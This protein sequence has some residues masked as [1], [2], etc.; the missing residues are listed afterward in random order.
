M[1]KIWGGHTARAGYDFRYQKWD[2]HQ[3]AAIRAGG[4]SSTASYT[5]ANNAA[6]LNDRAQSWAQFLLGLPTVGDRHGGERRHA[7]RASSRS[8]R[9]AQFSQTS[10]GLF[11]QD[12]WRSTAG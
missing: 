10:H 2:D 4:S 1:T 6:A 5:R 11:V 3:H 8:R 9:P 7:S 12:D